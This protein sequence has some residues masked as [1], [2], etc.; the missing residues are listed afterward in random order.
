ME[1]QEG[2]EPTRTIPH[3]FPRLFTHPL[4]WVLKHHLQM[5]ASKGM[6]AHTS[7]LSSGSAGASGMAPPPTGCFSQKAG[8]FF[9]SDAPAT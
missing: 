3:I 1:G 9:L 2:R 8:I 4:P 5:K 6:A 7:L